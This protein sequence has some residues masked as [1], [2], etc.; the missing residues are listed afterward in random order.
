M[1]STCSLQF[2]QTGTKKEVPYLDGRTRDL[3]KNCM[4]Y[5]EEKRGKRIADVISPGGS[6]WR[7]GIR[8]LTADSRCSLLFFR[9][10][11]SVGWPENH[12]PLYTNLQAL[13]CLS[14]QDDTLYAQKAGK[15]TL[16]PP[17]RRTPDGIHS[18]YQPGFHLHEVG[19]VSRPRS[20]I[21][22]SPAARSRL[23]GSVSIH[24]GP[25]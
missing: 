2:G 1:G 11:T 9:L 13:L 12:S 17:M 19:V 21:G 6:L 25:I 22:R 20:S 5:R 4:K 8:Q 18:R 15:P 16:Q 10:S 3:T 7:A 14:T 23:V 24:L